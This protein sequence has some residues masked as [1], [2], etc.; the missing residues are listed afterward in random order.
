MAKHLISAIAAV[1]A[2]ACLLPALALALRDV[3]ARK[4]GFVVQGRVLCDTCRA[5]L[6][7]LVSTYIKGERLFP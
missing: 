7:T 4:P 3:A 2:V 6:E 5:G 1:L